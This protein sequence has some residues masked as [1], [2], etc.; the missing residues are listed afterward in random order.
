MRVLVLGL[1][2][3]VGD[4]VQISRILG[5]HEVAAGH[6]LVWRDEF[7]PRLEPRLRGALG[8]L[9]GGAG[10]ARR[11]TPPRTPG[12]SGL[13]AACGI[14][15]RW[16]LLPKASSN[17]SIESRARMTSSLVNDDFFVWVSPPVADVGD[18]EHQR[19]HHGRESLPEHLVPSGLDALEQE[20][21]IAAGGVLVGSVQMGVDPPEPIVAVEPP[22]SVI[23][24][25][26]EPITQEI[27]R[28]TDPLAVWPSPSRQTSSVLRLDARQTR[29]AP[30]HHPASWRRP[31]RHR[32]TVWHPRPGPVHS[33][34]C[35]AGPALLSSGPRRRHRQRRH[36]G[37]ARQR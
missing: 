3:A 5:L 8:C 35:W 31:R 1:G 30:H 26:A 33:S 2:A 22:P 14:W 18:L 16:S 13:G 19:T 17:R 24:C 23:A 21:H 34:T 7:A 20:G 6:V 37:S 4:E 11:E 25:R 29:Q 32:H 10:G 12:A 28:P 36:A 27:E 9:S 15:P